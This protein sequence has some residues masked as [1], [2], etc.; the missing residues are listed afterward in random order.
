M[1]N[2]PNRKAWLTL[3]T[4]FLV[5]FLITLFWLSI[6]KYANIPTEDYIPQGIPE[7]FVYDMSDFDFNNK[8]YA[9]GKDSLWEHYP[10]KLYEP[11]NF[12]VDT[13]STPLSGKD[14]KEKQY[15]T[16]RSL[17]IMLF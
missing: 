6:P 1:K 11:W 13:S 2:Q 9:V 4:V 14:Y 3:N 17:R 5:L 15:F 12:P 10:E 16:H 7:N 8:I